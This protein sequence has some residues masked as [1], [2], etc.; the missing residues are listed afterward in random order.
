MTWIFSSSD[1]GLL[2]GLYTFFFSKSMRPPIL[3]ALAAVGLHETSAFFA[4]LNRLVPVT[5]RVTSGDV[6]A[7]L[8][9]PECQEEVE[10]QSGLMAISSPLRW[11]GKYPALSL[12]FPSIATPAQRARGASG[13]TLDFVL[14]TGANTNTINSLVATELGLGVVGAAPG[15]LGAGGTIA[16]GATFMLGDAEFADVPPGERQPFMGGLTAS[17]LP[18]ASPAA[19]GLPEA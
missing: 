9:T 7:V 13:V 17:A 10:Q 19:A 11:I 2:E 18:V 12:S 14:D 6:V 5:H 8:S 16:G 1:F 3:L 15:G 4:P